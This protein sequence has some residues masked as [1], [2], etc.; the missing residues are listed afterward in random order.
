MVVGVRK[1]RRDPCLG[2]RPEVV[3]DSWIFLLLWA[4]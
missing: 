3:A 4:V 1:A 2:I